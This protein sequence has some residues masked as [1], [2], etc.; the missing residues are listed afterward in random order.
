MYGSSYTTKTD[1]HDHE[2]IY[3]KLSTDL[4]FVL[5]Y[6][7]HMHHTTVRDV[8]NTDLFNPYIN[9]IIKTLV[10]HMRIVV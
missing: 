9:V 5:T 4:N 7:N 10:L 1:T 6:L 8:M 2:W 3:M